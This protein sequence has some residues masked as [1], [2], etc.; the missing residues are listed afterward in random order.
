MSSASF[1][2]VI[3]LLDILWTTTDLDTLYTLNTH[4][5]PYENIYLKNVENVIIFAIKSKNV[6]KSLLSV[7]T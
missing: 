2:F 6:E 1:V 5:S 7:L 3:H 4:N